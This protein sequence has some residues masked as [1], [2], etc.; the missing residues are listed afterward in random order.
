MTKQVI[1]VVGGCSVSTMPFS[2]ES[3][4]SMVMGGNDLEWPGPPYP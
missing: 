2:P 4:P 3:R 1:H